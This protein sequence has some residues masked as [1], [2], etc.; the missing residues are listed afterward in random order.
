MPKALAKYVVADRDVG[1]FEYEEADSGSSPRENLE[2]GVWRPVFFSAT[3]PDRQVRVTPHRYSR[4]GSRVNQRREEQ[5]AKTEDRDSKGRVETRLQQSSPAHPSAS[6]SERPSRETIANRAYE[7]FQTR[8][9]G[10]GRDLEDWFEAE[11]DL[12]ER[13]GD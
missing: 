7:L 3:S 9:G 2:F 5:M 13:P 6:K 8:G 4:T 12:I 1:G 11:R 10:D